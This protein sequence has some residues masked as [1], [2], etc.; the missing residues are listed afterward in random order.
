[1]KLIV[2]MYRSSVLAILQ[3]GI[4]AFRHTPIHTHVFLTVTERT[5]S[6]SYGIMPLGRFLLLL[7]T[8]DPERLNVNTPCPLHSNDCIMH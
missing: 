8:T 3:I 2:G 4:Y 6:D 7:N 1:M 5:V